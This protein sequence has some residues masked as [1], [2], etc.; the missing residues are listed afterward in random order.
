MLVRFVPETPHSNGNCQ[1]KTVCCRLLWYER[2]LM[3]GDSVMLCAL[4]N[5]VLNR[6]VNHH[7][8]NLCALN[9]RDTTSALKTTI[10]ELLLDYRS[11]TFSRCSERQ[12]AA[13]DVNASFSPSNVGVVC[14]VHCSL[15]D[16]VK[17]NECT[18]TFFF[19][20]CVCACVRLTLI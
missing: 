18:T 7:E 16:I 1:S 11:H 8:W 3:A 10:V 15:F 9:K 14:R 2:Q 5:L 12:L 4:E 19:F 13:G 20:L 17:V 6:D